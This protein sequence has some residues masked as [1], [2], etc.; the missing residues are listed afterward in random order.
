MS[1]NLGGLPGWVCIT[2]GLEKPH[3]LWLPPSWDH[4]WD[5]RWLICSPVLSAAE[6][7]PFETF[8]LGRARGRGWNPHLQREFYVPR[9]R[10][11]TFWRWSHLLVTA[12]LRFLLLTLS[13]GENSRPGLESQVCL[14]LPPFS[15]WYLLAEHWHQAGWPVLFVQSVVGRPLCVL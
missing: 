10:L 14:W 5:Q 6:Y 13:A 9:T 1:E 11:G 12:T 2:A 7:Y 8:L 15:S 4:I 3:F